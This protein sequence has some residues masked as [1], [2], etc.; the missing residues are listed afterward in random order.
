LS[1][2]FQRDAPERTRVACP[3]PHPPQPTRDAETA[4]A[5]PGL[6]KSSPLYHF[7]VTLCISNIN[8][9]WCTNGDSTVH[10]KRAATECISCSIS[11]TTGQQHTRKGLRV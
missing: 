7:P 5:I 11:E 4:K 10:Q 6:V 8:T 9:Q 3:H 2:P 1:S